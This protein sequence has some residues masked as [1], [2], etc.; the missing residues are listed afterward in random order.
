MAALLATLALMPG[1][2]IHMQECPYYHPGLSCAVPP[3]TIYLAP[4]QAPNP[5]NLAHELGHIWDYNHMTDRYR[6]AFAAQAG[7]PA[8]PW[9][10]GLRPDNPSA[11][12][13]FADAF[14]LCLIG[15]GTRRIRRQLHHGYDV[16]VYGERIPHL[17]VASVCWL[18]HHPPQ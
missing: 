14:A 17:A 11:G 16:G 7:V 6:A 1:L 4:A 5:I 2:T 18:R 12:E 15:P 13:R 10:D 3:N 8:E 9:L